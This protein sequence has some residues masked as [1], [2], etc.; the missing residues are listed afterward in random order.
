MQKDNYGKTKHKLFVQSFVPYEFHKDVFAQS[1]AEKS[2]RE[3]CGFGD[4]VHILFGKD[5]VK[6]G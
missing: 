4:T 3:K 2:K 6:D 1:T 5:F